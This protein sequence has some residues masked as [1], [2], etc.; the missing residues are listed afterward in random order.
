MKRTSCSVRIFRREL[1]GASDS[2]NAG[3]AKTVV[4][5]Q[6]KLPASHRLRKGRASIAGQIYLV[7][8]ATQGRKRLFENPQH[9][10]LFSKACMDRRLW[11]DAELLAWVLMPNHWHGLVQLGDNGVLSRVVQRLKAN[12][13]KA[14]AIRGAPVWQPGFHDRAI[15]G[16]RT[17]HAAADYLLANPLRAGLVESIENWPWR[18][19]VWD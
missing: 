14:V 15:A 6:H 4:H 3:S 5:M 19:A 7:T 1:G 10:A 18:Y 17:M 9:A 13:S 12:T 16:E 11:Q 2:T 8:F